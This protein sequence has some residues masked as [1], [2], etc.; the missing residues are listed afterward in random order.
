MSQDSG[1]SAATTTEAKSVSPSPDRD[2]PKEEKKYPIGWRR[3][4]Q[5]ST[6]Q[7]QK[8]Q[9]MIQE[10]E[11]YFEELKGLYQ[12]SPDEFEQK[13]SDSN[14][15]G[16]ERTIAKKIFFLS[17]QYGRDYVIALT[18]YTFLQK[19]KSLYH[20]G[21]V[22]PAENGTQGYGGNRRRSKKYKSGS[23][24][25]GKRK[26]KRTKKSRKTK[27]RISTTLRR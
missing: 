5:E 21:D 17:E 12:S 19:M 7:Q 3:L 26:G 18:P 15:N 23:K 4:E 14:E 6:L 10:V 25:K 11:Q 27:G 24:G 8:N 22:K 1:Y 20:P 9:A 13:M 2:E 16:V